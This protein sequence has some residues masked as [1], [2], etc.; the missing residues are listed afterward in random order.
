MCEHLIELESEIINS[1]VKET[2]R[3]KPWSKNCREWVYFD[4]TLNTSAITE[5]LV[6]PVC[7]EI[8]EHEG[9]HDGSE[10]G[11]VCNKCHDAI[12]GYHPKSK[13]AKLYG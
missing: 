9:T 7:V 4:C 10:K 5:R 6:L 11:L 13:K 3:G 2:Y 8:H 12:I 1:G